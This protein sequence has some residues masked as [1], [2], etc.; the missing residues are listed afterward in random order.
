MEVTIR[1]LEEADAFV[2]FKWRND[3]EVF[4]YTGNTYKNEIK[5]ET[6]LEWIRNVIKNNKLGKDFRCAILADGIYVGNIYLTDIEKGCADYHIFIGN[7]NYWGKGV[8]KRASQLI[9]EY[10]FSVLK[11]DCVNLGVRIL[12]TSA[13]KLYQSL[14]FIEIS[15]DEQWIWMR[16]SK[17]NIL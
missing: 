15:R 3:H 10:A 14:G 9:L 7:K 11:L 12:N 5:V 6:E 17:A 16:I 4:K 8:A 2:S 13:R 1:P